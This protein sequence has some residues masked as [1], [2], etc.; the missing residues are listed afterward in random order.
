MADIIWTKPNKPS[1]LQRKKRS[2]K[3]Y[4]IV[5][6]QTPAINVSELVIVL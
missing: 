5:N 3:N 4:K 1:T 2:E 6:T